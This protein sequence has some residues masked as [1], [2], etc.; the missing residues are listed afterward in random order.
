M[1]LLTCDNLLTN[2]KVTSIL[3]SVK[4]VGEENL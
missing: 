2:A 1:P 3:G 4:R